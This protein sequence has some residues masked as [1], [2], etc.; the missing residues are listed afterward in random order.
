M[1]S[2]GKGYYAYVGWLKDEWHD[3]PDGITEEHW[4]DVWT[5]YDAEMEELKQ[6]ERKEYEQARA[7]KI[8]VNPG[9]E[10]GQ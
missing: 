8:A 2:T 9:W 4:E 6:Q 1:D 3:T 5:D 7:Q 10:P